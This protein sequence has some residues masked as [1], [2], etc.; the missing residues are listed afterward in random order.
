MWGSLAY[1]VFINYGFAQ[2]I[3]SD[4]ARNLPPATSA[5]SLMAVPMVGTLSATVIVGEWPHWQDFVAIIFVMAAMAAVLLPPR[6][7]RSTA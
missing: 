5:M 6:T 1:G 7:S 4:L 3:W 2:I